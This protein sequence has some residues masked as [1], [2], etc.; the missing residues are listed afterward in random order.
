MAEV[1]VQQG[2]VRADGFI[3]Q[4]LA[5]LKYMLEHWY[6][7]LIAII[8]IILIAVVIYLLF[9]QKQLNRE[10]DEPGYFLFKKTTRDALANQDKRRYRKTYS[11]WNILWFGLPIL[12]KDRS[13]AVVNIYGQKIGAYRGHVDS[14]DGTIN[15]L[16]CKS[17]LL[18]WIDT[19]VLVKIPRIINYNEIDNNGQIVGKK[20]KIFDLVEFDR[21]DLTVKIKCIG[22]ERTALFYYMPIIE[23]EGSNDKPQIV[24]LRSFVE[25]TVMDSTYQVMMQRILNTGQKQMEKAMQFNPALKYAQMSPQKTPPEQD[26]DENK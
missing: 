18:G 5:P 1:I 12:W 14:Q 20:T 15:L 9:G 13:K 24:D 19:N 17:S 2:T 10:R 22:I 26:V 4:I 11:W 21:S 7:F 8:L 6:I 25:G 23:A 16:I 3:D